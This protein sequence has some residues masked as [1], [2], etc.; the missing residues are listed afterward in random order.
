MV[1]AEVETAMEMAMEIAMAM[2][3]AMGGVAVVESTYNG[4]HLCLGEVARKVKIEILR[5]AC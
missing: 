2:A 1:V 5:I 4:D 3:M